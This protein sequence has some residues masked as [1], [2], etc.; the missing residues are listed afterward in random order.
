MVSSVIQPPE[1]AMGEASKPTGPDF[2]Q[3]IDGNDLPDGVPVAGQF[4]GEAV[5]LLRRGDALFAIGANCTHYGGP[6][7]EGAVAGDTIRCPWHHACFSLRTGEA[8]AAPALNPVNA[9]RTAV[10]HGRVHVVGKVGQEPAAARSPDASPSSVV[11]VG[12]GAAGNAAAEML[13]RQ[14]YRGAVTV[15]S[16]D[17]SVPYDRPNLSKDYLAGNAPEEWIPLRSREFY[18]EQN[19]DLRTDTVVA[20]LDAD[21]RVLALANGETL[22]FGALLLAT[23][24]RPRRLPIPGAELGHVHVLRSLDDSR[25]LIDR[26][27]HAKRAVVLGAGFI[28][29]E[30]AASLRTRG[31]AVDVVAPEQQP[32]ERVVGAALGAMIRKVHQAHGVTFHLGQAPSAIEPDAVVLKDGSRLTTD[33]VVIGAGIVPET[34]LAEAAGLAVDRGV[35]VN[36]FLETSAPGIYAAGDIARWPDRHSGQSVRVEHWV[37]AQ[38]QGQV[39]ARNMLGAREPFVAVPFFWS[40]HYD[41]TIAYV[42]HAE[43]WDRVT[44]DGSPEAHDCRVEYWQGQ[45]RL[46]VATVGRDRESLLAEI[47]MEAA[48][49]SA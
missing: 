47:E 21:K 46:A 49:K 19:I 39:A 34:G 22:P 45:R 10:E 38:R 23:G 26:C 9:Y 31:L 25:A 2:E 20:R 24:G 41:V 8:V 28:G 40:S 42:G 18:R 35:K 11:I 12:G 43:A 30:V 48:L 17:P 14:G 16:A 44:I 6:L 36:A 33:L 1:D 27:K 29:L 15:L 7:V 37:V 5:L 3:G 4:R 13:R 32:L